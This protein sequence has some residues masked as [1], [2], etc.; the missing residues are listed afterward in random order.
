MLPKLDVGE[1]RDDATDSFE[2]ERNHF[3]KEKMPLLRLLLLLFAGYDED[4]AVGGVAGVE[5]CRL[6]LGAA[7]AL[8]VGALP[9]LCLVAVMTP[10]T[11]SRWSFILCPNLMQAI[12]A[13]TREKPFSLNP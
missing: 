9:G 5:L 12:K 10:A 11:R 7:D 2:V 4:D 8:E 13:S 3:K 6:L 1:S